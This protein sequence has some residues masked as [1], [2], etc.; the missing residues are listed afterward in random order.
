MKLLVIG[1]G[2]REHALVWKLAQS[3]RVSKIYCAPGNAGIA[4]L[5][6]CVPLKVDDLPGLQAFAKD[7]A[8][9]LT[10]VGPELPLS[11]GIADEF[12]KAKLR[13]FGPTRNAARIES[14]KSFAKELM[15]REK[16]P[17]AASRTFDRLDTALAWLE[18]C[19]MPIV[20]KADGLAQGKG[21]IIC[22]TQAEAQDAVRSMLSEQR[23]GEAGAR[24]VLEEFLEGEELTVMAFADGRTVIPM[25]P[26]QD[27]K[28]IGE[29][30]TGP[31]TGGMG[32]YAPAPLAT[33]EL[34]RRIV[35]EVLQPA[36]AGLSKLGSPFYGV[37]YAGLMIKDGNPYAL[38]FNARFGD[39]ET[40]VVLP[41]L[42]TELL[43]IIEAVVEHRLDQIQ[44]AWHDQ[45]AVCVVLTSEGYPGSYPTGLP[46][47]GLSEHPSE[48]VVVFHAGTTQPEQDVLTNG[49]RVLGVTALAD[50]IRD[51]Q[52]QAY[53]ALAPIKFEG[54]YYRSDIAHRVLSDI[55]AH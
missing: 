37:L 21:V 2:G 7:H 55:Q 26:A 4:Q 47:T 51:A 33:P 16:I 40:Q 17:T 48:A 46:I 6:E 31:N 10:I 1:N 30:D 39:P 14:S 20:V 49:G 36:V 22:A 11:L 3:P 52:K 27:H 18:T 45:S 44:V 42:Q 12:R 50:T 53:V 38:E 19:D 29:G 25:I 41:L 34:Q 54:S 24:V 5:A 13:I 9:D 23:F 15:V 43:D 35:E 32:A 8:I 28:R